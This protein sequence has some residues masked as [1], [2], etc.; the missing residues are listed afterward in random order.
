MLHC[1][2][3][4]V[5]ADEEV[6]VDKCKEVGDKV[7]SSM[8]GKNV[9]DDSFRKKDQV[10]TLT[11]KTAVRLN[12]GNI[13]VDP[14]LL[15]QRL[16]FVATGGQYDNPQSFFEVEMCSFIHQHYLI[17]RS[18]HV[19][20]VSP[21]WLTLS[22]L[23]RRMS[24]QPSL[25]ERFTTFLMATLSSIAFPGHGAYLHGNSL[26]LCTTCDPKV[27]PGYGSI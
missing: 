9:H 4:G 25:Q 24:K 12:E 14:Q 5:P 18:Y 19:W 10:I 6:N 13:Q 2:A 21:S 8:V 3:T 1:I 23:Q 7:L 27:Q 17:R 11:C 22:G 15:F 16:S 20:L 26:A